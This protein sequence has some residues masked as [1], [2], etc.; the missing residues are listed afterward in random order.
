VTSKK[1]K[2]NEKTLFDIIENKRIASDFEID[3]I[4]LGN[5][6]RKTTDNK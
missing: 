2:K 3:T 6:K 4:K 1:K 5:S